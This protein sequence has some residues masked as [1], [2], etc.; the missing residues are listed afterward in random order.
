MYVHRL[1]FSTYSYL[2]N[3]TRKAR[4]RDDGITDDMSV[5]AY[6]W[7]GQHNKHITGYTTLLSY[8]WMCHSME[9]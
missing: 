8:P 3:K 2:L 7:D 6:L 5:L 4:P 9:Q 1:V